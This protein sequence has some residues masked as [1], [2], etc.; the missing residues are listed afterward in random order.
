MILLTFQPQISASA[1]ADNLIT[2]VKS[3]ILLGVGIHPGF[4]KLMEHK[5]FFS[6]CCRTFLQTREKDIFFLNTL[7]ISLAPTHQEGPFQVMF[8]GTQHTKG[9]KGIEYT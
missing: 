7:K 8:A 5:A 1:K 9:A 4:T 3:G 2:A 6:T